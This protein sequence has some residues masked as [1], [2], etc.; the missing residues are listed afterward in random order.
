ML[1]SH[2]TTEELFPTGHQVIHDDHNGTLGTT[3]V[4]R[5]MESSLTGAEKQR[6]L[7][8]SDFIK[9]P[10]AMKWNCDHVISWL[11]E[12]GLG[13]FTGGTHSFALSHAQIRAIQRAQN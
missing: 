7:S 9:E 5:S 10:N 11:T 1:F 13:N 4:R 2:T 6:D 8:K 3:A 12:H